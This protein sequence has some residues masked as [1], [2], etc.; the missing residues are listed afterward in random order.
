MMALHDLQGIAVA[1]GIAI[2]KSFVLKDKLDIPRTLVADPEREISRIL[3]AVK[4]SLADLQRIYDQTKLD[5]GEEHAR[6]FEAHMHV[7]QDP[8]IHESVVD[9]IRSEFLNAEAALEDVAAQL[10]ADF[11][12]M[13][14]EYLRERAADI[15]DVTR[16]VLRH[17]L[18]VSGGN[19]EFLDEEVIVIARD[20]TPSDTLQLDRTLVKGFATEVGGRT[21]HTAIMARSLDLPAVVGLNRLTEVVKDGVL[22]ILDGNEGRVIIDPEPDILAAYVSKLTDEQQR[23]QELQRLANEETVTLDGRKVELGANIGTPVELDGVLRNGSEGVGLFRSEFLYM[24]R[25]NLPSE[26]E[27]FQAYKTVAE[28]MQGRPV[29]IRTLDIGGDKELPYLAL[30]EEMNPFLGYRAI[31]IC[32]DRTELFKVQLRAILRASHFGNVKIMYPMVAAVGEIRKANVILNEAKRELAS[33]NIL[34]DQEIEV[35]VMIEIPAAALAADTIAKEVAFFSIGTNDLIQ[36]TMACDRM[37]ERV[38]HLYQPYHPSVLQLIR[39]VIEA[40]HRHNKWAGM[41]G[42]MAGDL[43]AVP[44]LLGMGLDEFSMSASSIL[45]VRKLIKQLKYDE[46]KLWAMQA[47]E[48]ESQDEIKAFIAGKLE[49]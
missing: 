15:R 4:Q 2:A 24:N 6:I 13:D 39:H 16:R 19:L 28:K 44:I 23:K 31:R 30:P 29:V 40:A 21:S 18:G 14:N 12:L 38:S 34:F 1:N 7:L 17:L 9:T 47:L 11:E 20:L 45:P 46:A 37:N 33:D 3:N 22:L 25:D 10:I 42:E 49:A 48:L 32:L 36:Y 35:G 5:M 41:C 43:T 8:E 27:Q 26:E